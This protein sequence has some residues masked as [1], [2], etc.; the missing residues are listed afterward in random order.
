MCGEA[1]LSFFHNANWQWVMDGSMEVLLHLYELVKFIARR[2]GD[3][4]QLAWFEMETGP[5]YE[6]GERSLNGREPCQGIS[7]CS[8]RLYHCITIAAG[9]R[10]CEG[11]CFH[12][13]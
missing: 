9:Q 8:G 5:V 7:M 6:E 3:A 2:C 11:C 1:S 12:L 13:G 4:Y 10:T